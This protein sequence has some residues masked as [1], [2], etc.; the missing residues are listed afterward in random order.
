VVELYNLF[1]V[2]VRDVFIVVVVVLIA[3]LS[4]FAVHSEPEVV[5]F[6]LPVFD[7]AVLFFASPDSSDLISLCPISAGDELRV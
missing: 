2:Q 3:R 4:A 1:L 6:A 5:A 7:H